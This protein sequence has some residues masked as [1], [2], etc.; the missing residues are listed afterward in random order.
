GALFARARRDRGP[1]RADL[2]PRRGVVGRATQRAEPRR[3]DVV[4]PEIGGRALPASGG[5]RGDLVPQHPV[6]EGRHRARLVV[7]SLPRLRRGGDPLAPA[8]PRPPRAGAYPGPG[9]AG[10]HGAPELLPRPDR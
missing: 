6:T 8:A 2:D 7:P 1:S 3:D 9:R 10:G 4:G 5:A